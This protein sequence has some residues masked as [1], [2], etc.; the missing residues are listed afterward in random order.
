[1]KFSALM[2]DELPVNANPL[3]KWLWCAAKMCDAKQHSVSFC[4][5]NNVWTIRRK[6]SELSVKTRRRHVATIFCPSA[7]MFKT[8]LANTLCNICNSY[9]ESDMP[10]I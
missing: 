9:H 7:A 3:Q 1:M 6:G 4:F 8:Y 5:N 2:F 10:N